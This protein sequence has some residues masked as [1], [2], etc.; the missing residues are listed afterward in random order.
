MSG[1]RWVMLSAYCALTAVMQMQWLT[2]A[3]VARQARDLYG[4]SGLSIDLLSLVFML[5]FLLGS[6]P[7]SWVIDARGV[8]FAV[9]VGAALTATFA[10]LKGAFAES[11]A[12]VLVAQVGLALGQPFLLNASTKF[13]S[14]WFPLSQ[15]ALVVGLATLSQFVGIVVVMLVTPPLVESAS[16]PRAAIALALRVYGLVAVVVAGVTFVLMRD[17]PPADVNETTSRLAGWDA[18]GNVFAQRDMR[19]VIVLFFLGLGM[20]NA[21]S[22][23]IDAICEQKGLDVDQTGLVGG[24]MLVAGIVGGVVLP[25]L[26]DRARRR[27]PFLVGSMMVSALGVLGLAWF[28]DY[29]WLLVSSF[30]LGFFLLGGGAPIGFQYAAEVSHPVPETVAQGVILMSGQLSGILFIVGMNVI[31]MLPS[32]WIHVLFAFAIAVIT[33]LLRESPVILIDGR[34]HEGE[35]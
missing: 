4:V 18:I 2:F 15:R 21:I 29:T 3:P 10:V 8:K 22:T 16:E 32:L 28:T 24:I 27:K 5:V 19:L 30:V 20:F 23:C 34:A 7:A 11:Y 26:S 12:L 9:R 17:P 25:L 33:L 13:A 6:I 14:D 31:G 1:A 35:S